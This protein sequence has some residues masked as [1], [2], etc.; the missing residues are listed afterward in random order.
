MMNTF[1]VLNHKHKRE[2][3][4]NLMNIFNIRV[5]VSEARKNERHLH[6]EWL[7]LIGRTSTA[8]WYDAV[9][10]PYYVIVVACL[11]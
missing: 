10:T 5:G 9:R 7:A 2:R 3:G 11:G 8:F 1:A 4:L 6:T